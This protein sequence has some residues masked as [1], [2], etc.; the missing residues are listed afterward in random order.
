G[1]HFYGLSEP[2]K[3]RALDE[4]RAIHAG[5]NK[6]LIDKIY[7]L[8]DEKRHRPGVRTQL[9]PNL[10]LTS[11]TPDDSGKF[12]LTFRHNELGEQYRHLADGVVL[13]TGYT[14]RVPAFVRGISD[15]IRWDAHGRYQQARNYAVDITGQEVF[16]QNA[17]FHSHGITNPDLGL[18]CHRNA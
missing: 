2:M 14:H 5:I 13:A 12:A 7:D 11:L 3:L 4:Q 17:G 18:A 16:V 10:A 15:R 8:L 6:N 9:L 1:E